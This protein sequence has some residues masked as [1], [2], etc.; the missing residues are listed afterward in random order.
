MK[1]LLCDSSRPEDAAAHPHHLT[2]APEAL[3]YGVMS[4]SVLPVSQEEAAADDF[5]FASRTA[6]IV[7]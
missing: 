6:S 7:W 3:R 2:H 1:E 5:R 4:V